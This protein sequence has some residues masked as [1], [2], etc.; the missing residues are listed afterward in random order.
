LCFCLSDVSQTLSD[1]SGASIN[2]STEVKKD[3]KVY[4]KKNI[5]IKKKKIAQ[6]KEKQNKAIKDTQ[7][8]Q[9]TDKDEGRFCLC[10]LLLYYI[11][12]NFLLSILLF[13]KVLLYVIRI[14]Y[15][16]EIFTITFI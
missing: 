10:L 2:S 7:I 8:V 3:N 13:V 15:I 12:T 6:N 14:Y 5:Y 1:I 4:K 16:K 11:L 9:K